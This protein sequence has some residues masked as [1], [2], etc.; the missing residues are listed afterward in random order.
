[1]RALLRR[2]VPRKWREKRAIAAEAR[3]H[4]RYS[5]LPVDKVFADIYRHGEWGGN[6]SEYYSGSGSHEPSIVSPYVQ[7]V[8]TLL[9]NMPSPPVLVDLG[10]GD[11]NVGKNFVEL[12]KHYYA[13]DIVPDL[14]KHNAEKFQNQNLE[15]LCLN[16]VED[17]LPDGDLIVV[18]Q[19][20]Q[21]LS[22]DQISQVVRKCFKYPRWLITEHLPCG[23][24]F[25]PNADITA[26]CGIR[27][28]FKSGVVL[29]APPFNVEGY[30]TRVVCE[31]PEHG[32]VIRT[33]LFERQPMPSELVA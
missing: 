22:N 8:Q 18:R 4:L 33:T 30:S 16:A 10:S 3:R 28:L 2:I 13:C 26:G 17:D 25:Q 32:A 21:H 6:S 23:E 11:F 1:M 31:V 12:V 20:F 27:V 14:Q 29:T 19:V 15:F 7:A 5:N 9:R 24:E